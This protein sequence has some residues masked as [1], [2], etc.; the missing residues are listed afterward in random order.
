MTNYLDSADPG[1]ARAADGL[2]FVAGVTTNPTL[3]RSVTTDPLKHARELLAE[4]GFAELYHQPSGAYVLDDLDELRLVRLC[5]RRGD[6]SHGQ[7]PARSVRA[8]PVHVDRLR[9]W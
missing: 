3:M 9:V 8:D 6:A 1:E 7:R 5:L 2:G 4:T